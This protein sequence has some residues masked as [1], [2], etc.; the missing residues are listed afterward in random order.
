MPLFG[1][2][3]SLLNMYTE[4]GEMQ[5]RLRLFKRMSERNVVTLNINIAQP[6]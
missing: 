1:L 3:N 6:I 5:D 4:C 2:A